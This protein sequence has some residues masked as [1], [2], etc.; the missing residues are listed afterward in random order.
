MSGVAR[1][2]RGQKSGASDESI[3]D[4]FLEKRCLIR[5]SRCGDDDPQRLATDLATSFDSLG[6]C[7]P[8]TCRD[9]SAGPRSDRPERPVRDATVDHPSRGGLCVRP[10]PRLGPPRISSRVKVAHSR[11][12][13]TL[14]SLKWRGQSACATDRVGTPHGQWDTPAAGVT[15]TSGVANENGKVVDLCATGG[16]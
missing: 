1:N 5:S 13:T 10:W 7:D 4:Q 16:A 15:P 2:H 12:R 8:V 11:A 14:S 9:S 6:S 3:P